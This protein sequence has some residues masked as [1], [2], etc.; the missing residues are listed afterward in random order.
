MLTREP[1]EQTKPALINK[2]TGSLLTYIFRSI[3][4]IGKSSYG[5]KEIF[6]SYIHGRDVAL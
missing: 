2:G 5:N 1:K 4:M 6:L 3:Y